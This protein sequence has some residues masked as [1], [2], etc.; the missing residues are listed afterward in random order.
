[1][2]DCTRGKAIR[3]VLN[4]RTDAGGITARTTTACDMAISHRGR[5]ERREGR[6]VAV[7]GSG[8]RRRTQKMKEKDNRSSD[9]GADPLFRV[10]CRW[11]AMKTRWSYSASREGRVPE[12]SERVTVRTGEDVAWEPRSTA[13]CTRGRA[14]HIFFPCFVSRDERLRTSIVYKVVTRVQKAKAVL[15]S[16][17][18]MKKYSEFYILNCVLEDCFSPHRIKLLPRTPGAASPHVRTSRIRAR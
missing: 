9:D 15:S 2:V 16:P 8:G 4:T 6:R 7:A 11:L 12:G 1:M 14:S 18:P 13:L 17:V 5:E 3:R 10:I